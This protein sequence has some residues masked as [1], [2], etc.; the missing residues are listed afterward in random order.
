MTS[1][2]TRVRPTAEIAIARVGRLIWLPLLLA[3]VVYL[4]DRAM[5]GARTRL[6]IG[7]LDEPGH[8]ITALLVLL[9]VVGGRRL[10]AAPV[11][12]LTA[13][14]CSV[15]IDLDHIPLYAGVPFVGENGSRPYSHSL[16]TALVLL[17]GWLLTGRRWSVL[18]GAAVG[19]CLHFVRDVAS[20]PGVML[21]WPLSTDEV[22]IPHRWYLALVL[23]VALVAT[24]RAVLAA[25]RRRPGTGINVRT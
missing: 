14:A 24:V 18:L 23:V 2:W 20:G 4:I 15:L 19:V 7:V 3:A 21:T 8:L 25:R 5:D 10:A 11:F 22:R 12:T 9:A 1:T 16:T 6:V 17:I 13:L